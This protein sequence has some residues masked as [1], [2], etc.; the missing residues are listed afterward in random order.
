M[1]S[2]PKKLYHIH[3]YDSRTTL[4]HYFSN[5]E[6]M[7]FADDS[8]KFPMMNLHY[9]FSRGYIHGKLLMDFSKGS[10]I[11]HLYSASN[12]FKDIILMKFN[13]KSAMEVHRWLGD[14]TG[15]FDWTH[16]KIAVA[17]LEGKSDQSHTIELNLKASIRQIVMCSLE[18]ENLTDPLVL[19]LSDCIISVWLLDLISIDQDD[20]M[21]NLKKISNLLKI[22]G[23]LIL[24]GALNMTYLTV[25]AELFHVF[26]YDESFVKSALSKL[27]FVIDYCAVQKRKNAS[28]LTDY[29]HVIF[30]AAQKMV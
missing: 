15:A 10:Y 14:R 20:Y 18:K 5:K 2:V 22:G 13:E 24:I 29:T 25:G 19:P 1:D 3:G 27:G 8:L 30:V 26:K 11:H 23:H 28:D 4:E 6:D 7:I 21:K 12:I 17:E 9:V 16:T